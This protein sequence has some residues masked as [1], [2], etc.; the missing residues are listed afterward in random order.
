[1]AGPTHFS[2]KSYLGVY[3]HYI[4]IS[5]LLLGNI[6]AITSEPCTDQTTLEL[7]L[8]DEFYGSERCKQLFKD[9]NC[10][11]W[12]IRLLFFPILS[13]PFL[14]CKLL[15]LIFLQLWMMLLTNGKMEKYFVLLCWFGWAFWCLY[16]VLLHCSCHIQVKL[17][18]IYKL[19]VTVHYFYLKFI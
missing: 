3:W 12:E 10:Y 1:M 7:Y 13:S 6:F 15:L 5:H 19:F 14:L 9:M 17:W 4:N 18:L 8:K 16:L 2:Y 11:R